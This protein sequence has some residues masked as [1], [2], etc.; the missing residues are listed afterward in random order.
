MAKRPAEANASLRQAIVLGEELVGSSPDIPEYQRDLAWTYN[1]LGLLQYSTGQPTAG[2]RSLEQAVATWRRLLD[3]HPHADFRIGLGQA[4]SNLGWR[5]TLRGRMTEAVEYNQ[6]AVALNEVVV[7][8]HGGATPGFR[9]RLANSLDNLG[10]VYCYGAQPGQA[11]DAYQRAL[12]IAESLAKENPA[13]IEF[14]ERRIR[15]YID[16]GHLLLHATGQDTEARRCFETA[17]ELGKK[18]PDVPPSQF[19]YAY[20]H[21]G[22]GKL[23]RNQ[24]QT[25]AAL[26][27]FQK[28]VEIGT[29]PGH[30]KPL[31]TYELAC[32]RALCSAVLGE[33]K[34]ELTAEEQAAKRR[35]ADQAMEALRQAVKEGWENVTWMRKDP[36]LNALR[37]RPDLQQLLAELE[38]KAPGR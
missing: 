12:T 27:A 28:A 33:G 3:K 17:V 25:A 6:K 34:A 10:N 1:N 23:L 16:F 14:Q 22:L 9:S 30:E 18:L 8:E 32:A 26:K 19:S 4:Y 15:H 5:L 20:I 2:E 37:Q 38:A 7:Q 13:V 31:V 36:D 11:R 24:G 35:Y 21:R 29:N